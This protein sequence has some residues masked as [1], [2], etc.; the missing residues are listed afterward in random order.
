ML[1]HKAMQPT[2]INEYASRIMEAVVTNI[3]AQIGGNVLNN[4][5]IENLP[6]DACVEVPCLVN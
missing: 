5:F 2:R 4:G 1:C 3:P 6:A